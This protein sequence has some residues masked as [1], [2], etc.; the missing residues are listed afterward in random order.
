MKIM[1]TRAN[2][3][4]CSSQ[5]PAIE[6]RDLAVAYG[7]RT[8]IC[9]VNLCIEAGSLTALI[10]PS[11]SGKSTFLACLNRMTDLYPSCCVNG[12]VLLGD[13]DIFL[14][15]QNVSVL[16]RRVGMIFQRPIALPMSIQKNMEL[17]MKLQGL[18]DP[19]ELERR[20]RSTLE[21][22]G[23][24]DE[25]KDR[26]AAP[27]ERLSGGQLQRLCLARALALDP[28]VILLDEPC[29]ALDPMSSAICE[30]LI[31]SLRGKYTVVLVT[32]NLAQARRLAD[33]V[34]MFWCDDGIGRMVESSPADRFFSRPSSRAANRYLEGNL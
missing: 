15:T 33:N 25:I 4:C 10:G 18:R 3:A 2:A 9:E 32:H 19:E 22:V 8:A 20:T 14:P 26:M 23:L 21:H 29:S 27:A 30:D 12:R 34:A 28:E 6:T 31:K 16:R 7:N 1:P 13:D 11:G 17:P 5:P 24:W